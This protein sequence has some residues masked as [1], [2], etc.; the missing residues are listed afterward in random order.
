M[1]VV[2]SMVGNGL[3]EN[4]LEA[5]SCL[6]FECW[7]LRNVA[8]LYTRLVDPKILPYLLYCCG[9]TALITLSRTVELHFR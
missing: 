8:C 9:R 7:F 4:V 1:K 5:G 3:F 6:V 2:L